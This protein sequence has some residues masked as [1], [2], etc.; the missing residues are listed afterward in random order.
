MN[1]ANSTATK[2]CSKCGAILAANLVNFY[3]QAN[4]RLGLTPTCRSCTNKMRSEWK[5]RNSERLARE[6]REAYARDNG[7]RHRK[8]EIA[9]A[10]RSP[11]AARARVLIGGIRERSKDRALPFPAWAKIE[12][13]IDWL[14]RQPNC[15]CCGVVFAMQT[16]VAGQKCDASP[17][18]DRFDSCGGYEIENVRLICWRCNNIKRNYGAADLRMVADWIDG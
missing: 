8:R 4:C 3:A 7:E 6:R 18:F 12:F 17:S 2:K 16:A 1:A 9:R 13:V 5:R 15:E 14:R 11:L 10:A